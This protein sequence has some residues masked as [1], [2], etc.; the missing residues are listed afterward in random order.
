[1]VGADAVV[2]FGGSIGVPDSAQIVA[3]LH[4]GASSSVTGFDDFTVTPLFNVSGA[5]AS[6][7]VSAFLRPA[8]SFG[9]YVHGVGNAD[10]S[11]GVML[12]ELN[13]TFTAESGMYML[14]CLLVDYLFTYC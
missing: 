13:A 9:V 3:D 12:P 2:D 11:V 4:S 14:L 8:L 5:E 6:V 1:M 7:S 10:I